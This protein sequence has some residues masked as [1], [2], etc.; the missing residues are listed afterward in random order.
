LATDKQMKTR[1]TNKAA[2][3]GRLIP[4]IICEEPAKTPPY[5]GHVKIV[6]SERPQDKLCVPA[7]GHVKIVIS[8]KEQ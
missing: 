4:I 8:D 2:P 7:P 5:V 3:K 6:I 1:K